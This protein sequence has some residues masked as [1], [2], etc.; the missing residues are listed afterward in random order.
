MEN[1][2]EVSEATVVVL[3]WKIVEAMRERGDDMTV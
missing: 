1:S 3:I 2:K